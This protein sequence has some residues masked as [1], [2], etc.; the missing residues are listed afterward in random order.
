MHLLELHALTEEYIGSIFEL[1]SKLK[2]NPGMK[3]LEGK[4]FVLVFPETSLRTRVTFEKGILDLGGKC[5]LFPPETLDKKECLKD[6]T[7]YLSNWADCL[8]I[9][10]PDLP[11]LRELARHSSIPIINAMTKENHPCEV[12]SDLYSISEIRKGYRDLTY[13]FVGPAGNILKSWSDIAEV[14]NLHFKHVGPPGT[15][16]RDNGLYYQFIK[17]LDEALG[18]SDVV[19]TDSLTSCNLN[20]DY[21]RK[22]Q[23]TSEK[24]KLA[25]KG[26]MLNPCP[27]FFR[28][29]EVSDEVIE[30]EYFVGYSFKKNLIHVQQA[31]VSYCLNLKF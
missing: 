19:L 15:E 25:N 28:N 22:Y 31:I 24:M 2:M 26:A 6:V 21:I 7:G 29:E 3:I 14:L 5:I 9:R 1:A 4:T 17:D 27:P 16:I 13:T 18:G 12:L 10:H 30:S 11:K 23:I 8:I 20:E